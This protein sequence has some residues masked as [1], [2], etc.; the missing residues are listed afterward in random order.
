MTTQ[1]AWTAS[2]GALSVAGRLNCRPKLH[3]AQLPEE[4]CPYVLLLG[5]LGQDGPHLPSSPRGF[6]N[7]PLRLIISNSS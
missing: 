6:N 4:I 5:N 2:G 7:N 3:S 1:A